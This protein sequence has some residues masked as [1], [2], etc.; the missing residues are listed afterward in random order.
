[1]IFSIHQRP[2]PECQRCLG[3]L[4]LA[5]YLILILSCGLVVACAGRRPLSESKVRE[6]IQGLGFGK[7]EQMRIQV[8]KI[9]LINE[10][11]AVAEVDIQSTLQIARDKNKN[12]QIQ[13]LRLGDRSWIELKAFQEAFNQ[14]LSRQT[15]ESLQK[16]LEGLNKYKQS[17]GSYPEAP[18]ITKL[19]DTLVPDYMP[20]VIR[21]DAWNRPLVYKVTGANSFQL[22]SPGPDGVPGTNDDIILVP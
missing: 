18:D 8:Q 9:S 11:Q 3:V 20:D 17:K 2:F 13:A 1:M 15:R 16:L 6:E 4:K 7:L 22:S 5:G 19:T 12:W 14:V 10:N 21:Y